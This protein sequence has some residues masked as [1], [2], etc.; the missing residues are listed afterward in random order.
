MGVLGLHNECPPN[1]YDNAQAA[2]ISKGLIADAIATGATLRVVRDAMAAL[3][4]L[5][6]TVRHVVG[7]SGTAVG[8]DGKVNV[9]AV[10]QE[11]NDATSTYGECFR[12]L[13]GTVGQIDLAV[14]QYEAL[15]VESAVALA[16]GRD[17]CFERQLQR[18]G[19]G[20]FAGMA[21]ERISRLRKIRV[22]VQLLQRMEAEGE[23][24]LAR[25]DFG[26]FFVVFMQ[27]MRDLALAAQDLYNETLRGALVAYDT[28]TKVCSGIN[29]PST[30]TEPSFVMERPQ[31]AAV[32]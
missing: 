25:Y 4:N 6:D 18:I 22:R 29:E 32:G 23:S 10:T 17:E 13:D 16:S 24:M 11:L 14:S 19:E 1:S 5:D 3:A 26:N 27:P 12:A 15:Q 7:A 9:D 20:G 8:P 31:P 30:A 28:L 21:Q 2:E